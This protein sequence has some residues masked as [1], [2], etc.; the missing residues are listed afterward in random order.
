MNSILHIDAS[1]RQTGSVSRELSAQIVAKLSDGQASVSYR[2]VSQ[3]LPFVDET[4]IGSYFTAPEQ[5]SDAQRQSIAVSD[6]ITRELQEHD[7]IVIG[8]P[9]YNFSMP[10]AF[11]AW[12]DLAARVG[13]T[14]RYTDQGPVGL[15]EGKKAIVVISSG[16]TEVGSS[17]DFLS[18]WLRHYLG[19]IG[20]HD[21]NIVQADALNQDAEAALATA[22]Q[23]IESLQ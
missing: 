18:P 10:S 19:F 1:G 17:I 4:M 14:F 3:G 21:V 15:L 7:L 13:V 23:Q 16:G 2:D 12:C 20:I 5:R 11:K 6:E 8:L 22:Q 9:I